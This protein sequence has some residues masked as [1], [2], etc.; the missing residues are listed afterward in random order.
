MSLSPADDHVEIAVRD[1]G[2]GIAPEL[3]PHVFERF[4]QADS[5]STRR[6]GGLGIGLAL[7]QA[8]SSS[9]TAAP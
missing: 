9:C 5:S 8:T 2:Q 4:R 3:L 1:T 6:Q 7:V